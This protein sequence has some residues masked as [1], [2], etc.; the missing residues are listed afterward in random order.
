MKIEGDYIFTASR[1]IIW[2]M[3][4]DPGMLCKTIP[5]CEHLDQLGSRQFD[6]AMHISKGPLVGQYNGIIDLRDVVE[7]ESLHITVVGS[8]P[9]GAIQAHG[10]IKLVDVGE[11]QI[12][13]VYQGELILDDNDL[14]QTPRLIRT[15]ANA[16]LRKFFKA[17]TVQIQIQTAVYTTYSKSEPLWETAVSG[18]RQKGKRTVDTRDKLREVSHNRRLLVFAAIVAVLNMLALIGILVSGRTLI[19]WI[20]GYFAQQIVEEVNRELKHGS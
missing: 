11:K 1:E 18:Q 3:L 4:L 8:G 13:L 7:C 19:D 6:L 12:C 10:H 2:S 15:T 17:L 9:I 20:R 5:G 16:Q 14:P